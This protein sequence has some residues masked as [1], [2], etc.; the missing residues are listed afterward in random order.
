MQE[1]I[2]VCE[3]PSEEVFVMT[4]VEA[5]PPLQSGSRV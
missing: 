2:V 3:R 1:I 5:L 4:C